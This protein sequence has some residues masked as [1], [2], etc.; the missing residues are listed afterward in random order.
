M[1]SHRNVK[2]K[3]IFLFLTTFNP[4]IGVSPLSLSPFICV[5]VC[6]CACI[7]FLCFYLSL[8]TS[9]VVIMFLSS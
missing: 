9:I 7:L 5:R 3:V 4:S 8:P 6:A 1:R 2:I